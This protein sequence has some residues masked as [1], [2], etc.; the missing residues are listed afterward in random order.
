M[1]EQVLEQPISN[2][3]EDYSPEEC[4]EIRKMMEFVPSRDRANKW[5]NA[6]ILVERKC[7][8]CEHLRKCY[9]S[10]DFQC[11]LGYINRPRKDK[12]RFRIKIDRKGS[13]GIKV[14]QKK[15]YAEAKK[16]DKTLHEIAKKFGISSTYVYRIRERGKAE[17]W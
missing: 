9:S 8:L 16:G 12:K 5:R 7:N 15:V 6:E 17:G 13:F 10:R 2:E 3:V 14:D 1:I 4:I 11:P